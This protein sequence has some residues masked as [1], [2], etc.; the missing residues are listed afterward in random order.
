M[1]PR[2]RLG[3]KIGVALV[4]IFLTYSALTAWFMRYERAYER[5]VPETNKA[6]VLKRFGRPRYTRKCELPPAWDDKPLDKLS[7]NCAE[8]LVYFSRTKIGQWVVG[9]DAN[10][11]TVT[12]YHLPSP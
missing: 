1:N 2:L 5:M 3:A 8:E 9:L 11:K 10:G 7:T 12:K 6:E 4:I